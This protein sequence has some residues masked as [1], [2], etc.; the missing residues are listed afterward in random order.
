MDAPHAP[1]GSIAKFFGWFVDFV[2][3]PGRIALLAEAKAADRD[4]RPV[5][6]SCG[7]GRVGGLFALQ[8]KQY[9]DA[10]IGGTCEQCGQR[11]AFGSYGALEG[12]LGPADL[13]SGR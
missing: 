4:P 12:L 2:K 11:W 1:I 8:A 13:P 3:M 6:K 9:Y 10:T 7:K 5:C